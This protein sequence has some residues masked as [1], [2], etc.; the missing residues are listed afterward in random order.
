MMK[1]LTPEASLTQSDNDI[2]EKAFDNFLAIISRDGS[3]SMSLLSLL[4]DLAKARAISVLSRV[5]GKDFDIVFSNLSVIAAGKDFSDLSPIIH[6]WS[7]LRQPHIICS[8]DVVLVEELLS[9]NTIPVF[10]LPLLV[11]GRLTGLILFWGIPED[12]DIDDDSF[13]QLARMAPVLALLV[14]QGVGKISGEITANQILEESSPLPD[15]SLQDN[16]RLYS[17]ILGN[18]PGLIYRCKNDRDWTMEFVSQGCLSLTGYQP[19]EMI[20]SKAIS[21]GE[22]VL[23]EHRESLWEQWQKVLENGDVFQGEYQIRSADGK[24]KWV[25]EQGSG[26]YNGD[27]E[28]I[29]LEGIVMDITGKKETE[30]ELKASREYNRTLF[31]LASIGLVLT[32]LDGKLVDMNP[33][34]LGI[35]GYTRE[36]ALRLAYR[37]LIPS[38]YR[39]Q[40]EEQLNSL[41]NQGHFGLCEKEYIHKDGHLIP[42]RL[43]GQILVEK[44]VKYIWASVEDISEQKQAEKALKES[45][46]LLKEAQR[47]G[48]MG[49]YVLDMASGTWTSSETLDRLFGIESTEMKTV[50]SWL[51]FILPEYRKSIEN[52]FLNEVIGEGKPFDRVYPVRR[53]NDQEV[54]W[55]HGIG[56]LEFNDAGQPVKMFGV[57]QDI[58]EDKRAEEALVESKQKYKYLFHNNPHPMWI[59]DLETY[60]FIEVNNAAVKH[61]GYSRAEFLSMTIKDIRPE[62]DVAQLMIDLGRHEDDFDWAGEWRHKKKN[63][64]IISVAVSSHRLTFNDRPARL[65]LTTDVTERNKALKALH[66]SEER[67]RTLFSNNHATMFLIDKNTGNIIDANQAAVDFYGWTYEELTSM[68]IAD[69][70]TLPSNEIRDKLQNVDY[71][72]HNHYEFKHRKADYSTC[73]VEV[74]SGPIVLRGIPMVH[75]I[76]HD[77]TPRKKAEEMLLTLSVAVEQSP[78]SFIITGADGLIQYVN[79]RF[80]SL[81][82]YSLEDVKGRSPRIMNPGHLPE[83]DFNTMLA[84]LRQGKEWKGEFLNR[85]KDGKYYWENVTVSPIVNN[86]GEITQ[87]IVIMEDVTDKKRAENEL[88]KSEASLREAQEIARMGDWEY[89]LVNE[90]MHSSDNCNKIFGLQPA[91]GMRSYNDFLERLIPDDQYLIQKLFDRLSVEKQMLEDEI[92]IVLPDGQQRW[93]NNRIVPIFENGV[94]IRLK[95]VIMDVTEYKQMEKALVK[96]KEQAEEGDKLKSAFLANISHEIRTPMNAIVGF[97]NLLEEH[98]ASDEREQ[99]IRIINSNAD[100]LLNIIDDVMAVSRLDTESIPLKEMD[101]SPLELM[102]DLHLSF[103]REVRNKPI[104]LTKSLPAGAEHDKLKADREKIRQVMSSFLSNAIKYTHEGIIEIGYSIASNQVRFFVRD[105]GMGIRKEEQK[106]IFERFYRTVSVQK[107]AIGG[108]GLGLSIAESLVHLMGGEIGV[109][110]NPEKG[111]VFYFTIPLSGKPGYI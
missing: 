81:T 51:G 18:V 31:N 95:G 36:E 77:V 29:A 62:E 87:Y 38:V 67:Y 50:E 23:E 99:F 19:D 110:S 93:L 61:Y 32:T 107:Q 16:L 14:E 109:E 105:T 34:M 69:I 53:K 98:I 54:R 92:R 39:E 7:N 104:A 76:V 68:N 22:L 84:A 55:L 3:F 42:V 65:V 52:Y 83:E 46:S 44:G 96:A 91:K 108:T 97:T 28:L 8:D 26:I 100:H 33:A 80:S 15:I 111:S 60:Q 10:S 79:P 13:Q 73:S 9:E 102:E 25:W 45:E 58:T 17:S 103:R 5:N 78:A 72:T 27:G 88:K 89:D 47:V 90:T 85:K 101:F 37:D 4:Q 59:Y 94:L 70:N 66:D 49:H 56:V 20:G 11:G 24:I 57:I 12:A 35:I 71:S 63:G 75:A 21:Y 1:N 106:K 82:G 41:L 64:E 6:R 86:V 74:F 43:K 30:N 2:A 40:E 48:R